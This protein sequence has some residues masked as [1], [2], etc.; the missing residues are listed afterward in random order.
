MLFAGANEAENRPFVFRGARGPRRTWRQLFID[1]LEAIV[2][3]RNSNS[4]MRQRPFTRTDFGA[5]RS[6]AAARAVLDFEFL[7]R[8]APPSKQ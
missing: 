4:R 1:C 7:S 6:A 3:E 2:R 8:F 5:P